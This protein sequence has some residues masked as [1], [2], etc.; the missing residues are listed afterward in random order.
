MIFRKE[1][2]TLDSSPSLHN[3][4]PLVPFLTTTGL[5]GS[6]SFH[7]RIRSGSEV[8][9]LIYIEIIE[10]CVSRARVIHVQRP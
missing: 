5:I 6:K 1:S 3:R 4:D 7:F 9:V 10:G 8:L 2:L